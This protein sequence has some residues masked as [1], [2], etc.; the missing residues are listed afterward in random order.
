MRN[1]LLLRDHRQSLKF[2][3]LLIAF[4]LI[5][6]GSAPVRTL[7]AEYKTVFIDVANNKTLEYGAEERLTEALV[8]EFQRDGH[9]RQVSEWRQADLI[10]E[11]SITQYDL[12][13]VTLD[14]DNRAAGRNLVVTVEA[15]A[16]SP[17][18]GVTVMPKKEFTSSGTFF[19]SN[20]PGGRREEDV[21]RKIAESLIATLIEGW[22]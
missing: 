14:N 18:T 17:Q 3:F 22:G 21:Y 15:Q 20:V 1:F 9:L 6:C 10:L 13:T 12:D 4:L 8:R 2:A 5:G 11:V 19:L 16:R 7:P